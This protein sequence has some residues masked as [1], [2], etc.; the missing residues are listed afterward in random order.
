MPARY[1]RIGDEIPLVV[2]DDSAGTRKVVH[3]MSN[4]TTNMCTLTFADG[5]V[6]DERGESELT[7][8][9]DRTQAQIVADIR[10]QCEL[11]ARLPTGHYAFS[12]PARKLRL[13]DE[14][15]RA[16]GHPEWYED[17]VIG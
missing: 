6:A 8:I 16:F 3:V 13:L 10:T 15:C 12:T 1:I 2:G 11:A 4:L 14:E 17:T 5:T 9:R 7:V